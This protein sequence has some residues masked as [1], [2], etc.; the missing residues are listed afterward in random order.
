MKVVELSGGVGG[1]RLA[2]GLAKLPDVDLT[3]IVNIGD[4]SVVHGLAVSPDIDTVLYTLAGA[5][6]PYGWGRAKDTFAFNSELARF[7]LDN[8]FALG[9]MDLA[10][11][12]ARTVWIQEGS[13]LTECTLRAAASLGV[14]ARVLPSTNQRVSTRVQVEDG[15]I[16]F[17]EYFVTRR[18]RD[19]VLALDFQGI[20]GARVSEQVRSAIEEADRLIIGPSNPPLSIWPILDI[21][22]MRQLLE[23]R[24]ITVVSPLIGGGAVKGPVV[25]V[26]GSLGLGS[27]NEAVVN[28]Y[29]GLATRLVIHESDPTPANA[30][31][32]DVMKTDTLIT[33]SPSAERLARTLVER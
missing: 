28:A 18:H 27:G 24:D 12:V 31:D 10:L 1:A 8:S 6:G 26:M 20:D 14:E 21:P 11:K 33:E 30:G 17:R 16:S 29:R 25:E 4:D 13:T 3:V 23:E 7:G 22:G 2:R 15:W 9:D 19:R 32:V 5:E